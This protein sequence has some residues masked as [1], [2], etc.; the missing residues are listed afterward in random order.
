MKKKNLKYE[1]PK[2]AHVVWK[3]ACCYNERGIDEEEVLEMVGNPPKRNVMVSSVGHVLVD[4]KEGITLAL[5]RNTKPTI[6]EGEKYDYD[7]I[8]CVPKE[9]IKQKTYLK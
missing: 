6:P 7:Y 9:Y 8:L 3:D 2:V 4:D 5:N 1:I